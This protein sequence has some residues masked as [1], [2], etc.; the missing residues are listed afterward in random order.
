MTKYIK[1][2]GLIVVGFMVLTAALYSKEST[3]TITV[4]L[5]IETAGSHLGV[6][7]DPFLSIQLATSP[8]NGN[9]LTTDG[10]DNAWG[11]CDSGSGSIDWQKETT[12]NTLSLT[13]TTTIPL[14]VK[15]WI[16]ASS[17]IAVAGD[18][19]STNLTATGTLSVSGVA[20]LNSASIT[21]SATVG[22]T[23]GITGLT[24]ATGGILSLASTTL[25]DFTFTNAT[26]TRAT[27][28]S[29]T[30]TGLYV[31]GNSTLVG[32][33][34][35]GS[36]D[37]PDKLFT[38]LADNASADRVRFNSTLTSGL[39]GIEWYDGATFQAVMGIDYSADRFDLYTRGSGASPRFSVT[40]AG[41]VGI[42][43]TSPA[44]RL[45]VA[46]SIYADALILASAIRATSS[47][48]AP[49]S[50]NPTVTASGQ[51]AVDTTSASTSIRFHDG[52]NEYALYPIRDMTFIIPS[53]TLNAYK[54][55]GATSTISWGM[56]LHAETW[57][58]IGCYASTTGTG[59]LMFGDASSNWMSYIPI[60]TT[61]TMTALSSNNSFIRGER[62]TLRIRAETTL[63]QD[64][65]CTVSV[66][67]DAD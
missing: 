42:G 19:T 28:T 17:S 8:S 23:L 41:D 52:T 59:G 22:T 36:A 48:R 4:N 67:R 7:S 3:K 62:R 33:V 46:D 66:R 6:F 35:V 64:I 63:T 53:S 10:T 26:G 58:E 21:T 37:A 38:L 47:L 61:P 44:F 50:A 25:Q 5:P 16:Y 18:I 43:T 11:S 57:T 9:C 14:W 30:S 15:D 12:Y 39:V 20:T 13:P 51:I 2:S 1:I 31:T 32:S 24:T 27:T 56:A 60:T 29:F 54:G 49:A 55:L 65:S 40:S 45:S 34:M